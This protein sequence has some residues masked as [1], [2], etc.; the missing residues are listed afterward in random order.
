MVSG[1][2]KSRLI[3]QVHDELVLQVPVDEVDLIQTRLP[4]IM[5]SVGE[6]VLNVPLLAEVGVGENWDAAH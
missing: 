4:E 3:M 6:G 5:A 2:L 1:S